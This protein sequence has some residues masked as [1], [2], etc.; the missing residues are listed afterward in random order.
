MAWK[1]VTEADRAPEAAH[2]LA[3]MLIGPV[4]SRRLIDR[5]PITD[6]YLESVVTGWLA[7]T[8]RPAHLRRSPS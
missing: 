8:S 6:A 3:K 5:R 2:A 7:A 1:A 4:M